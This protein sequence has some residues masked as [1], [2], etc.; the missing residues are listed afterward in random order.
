MPSIPPPGSPSPNAS[1]PPGEAPEARVEGV[2]RTPHDT[3][4]QRRRLILWSGGILL[5]VL[6][7]FF[8]LNESFVAFIKFLIMLLIQLFI[9][10]LDMVF[11][12]F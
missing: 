5:I 7:L 6:A 11:S 2:L 8:I 9:K 4:R 1:P 10:S 3:P 12:R